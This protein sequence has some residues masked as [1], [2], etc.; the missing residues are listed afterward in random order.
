MTTFFKVSLIR[1][2]LF[3][4]ER[5]HVIFHDYRPV[6][7]KIFGDLFKISFYHDFDAFQL[8][9]SSLTNTYRNFLTS[10]FEF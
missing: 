10:N 9:F 5:N 1:S 2:N 8:S 7:L 6:R 4:M 3:S